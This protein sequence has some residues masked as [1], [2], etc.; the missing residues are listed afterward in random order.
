MK[1]LII[2][3]LLISFNSEARTVLIM[4][5]SNAKG[6]IYSNSI[7]GEVIDC[8][9]SG[10]PIAAF[11][12]SMVSTSIFGGCLY[13][14]IGKHV[15]AIVFWQG[16]QDTGTQELSD[17]WG[18]SASDVI[19]ELHNYFGWNTPLIMVVLHD[20]GCP[21]C[22]NPGWQSVRDQQLNFMTGF[23][24]ID[25]GNYPFVQTG[26]GAQIHLTVSGYVGIANNINSWL[27]NLGV[28][29]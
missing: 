19:R 27:D 18:S 8:A 21:T 16:E 28:K 13:K 2:L 17:A 5:Q 12:Y 25:S 26:I 22:F 29:Q 1:T 11:H 9:I 3:L 10:M 15:D 23:P 14:T 24:K 4:G 7:Q 6:I 20:G